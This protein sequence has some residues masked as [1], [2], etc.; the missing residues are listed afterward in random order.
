[1][2]NLN[3]TSELARTDSIY[4]TIAVGGKLFCENGLYD[5]DYLERFD[6]ILNRIKI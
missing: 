5:F 4:M 6:V 2:V 1:M 3:N